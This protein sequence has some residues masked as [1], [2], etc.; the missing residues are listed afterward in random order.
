MIII[1]NIYIDIIIKFII[2]LSYNFKSRYNFRNWK[3]VIIKIRYSS[4][5]KVEESEILFDFG[6]NVILKIRIYLRK[7]ISN[8]KIKKITF[9]ISIRG[10]NNKIININKYIIITIY[11]KGI[12][13]NIIKITYFIIK[14]HV[15]NNFKTN[16]LINT[17]T[18]IL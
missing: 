11:I 15:M 6:Y 5:S 9:I 16:I 1:N 10:V 18:I 17:N 3:Y 8:L 14:V 13:N 12:I 2:K 4:N 7:Y